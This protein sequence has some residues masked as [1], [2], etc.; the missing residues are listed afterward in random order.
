MAYLKIIQYVYLAFSVF[1]IY[2][3]FVQYKAGESYW[4]SIF[5]ALMALGMFFFRRHYYNKNQKRK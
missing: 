5:I 3:A 1:F 4:L 2:N